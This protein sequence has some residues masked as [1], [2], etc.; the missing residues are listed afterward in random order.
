MARKAQH[1]GKGEKRSG[2]H[3]LRLMQRWVGPTSTALM[4]W[5]EFKEGRSEG[6]LCRNRQN[7]VPPQNPGGSRCCTEG[8]RDG[9][10]EGASEQSDKCRGLWGPSASD[11]NSENHKAAK[12]RV[13]VASFASGGVGQGH[14]R[15]CIRTAKRDRGCFPRGW[16]SATL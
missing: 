7:A 1:V 6:S 10:R 3:A 9:S 12:F 4:A 13:R 14:A 2:A 5:R 16:A 8:C 15:F 11:L